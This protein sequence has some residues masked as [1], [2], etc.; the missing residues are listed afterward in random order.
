MLHGQIIDGDGSIRQMKWGLWHIQILQLTC[1]LDHEFGSE[2][3]ERGT[4]RCLSEWDELS[5]HEQMVRER[6]TP[7]Y[8]RGEQTLNR[9][10][11]WTD[12]ADGERLTLPTGTKIRIWI[13]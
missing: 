12:P 1:N 3:D 10:F 2:L 5:F 6:Q 4:G 7:L 11:S 9:F 8:Q 13:G